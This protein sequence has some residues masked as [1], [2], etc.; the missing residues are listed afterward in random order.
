MKS[1]YFYSDLPYKENEEPQ[2]HIKLYEY[3]K[4]KKDRVY[5]LRYPI[6]DT[7]HEDYTENFCVLIPGHKI[8]IIKESDDEPFE[9]YNEDVV[10][11]I[12]YLYQKYDY[13]P[14]LGRFKQL[15]SDLIDNS[16]NT[17]VR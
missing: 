13:R 15:Q 17:M 3:S 9:G 4:I 2:W 6:V 8:A 5:V 16:F 12:S 7:K 1:N 14:K 10:G 11:A